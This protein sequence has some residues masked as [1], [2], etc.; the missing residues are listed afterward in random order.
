MTEHRRKFNSTAGIF[1]LAIVFA[2]VFRFL[3]KGTFYPTLFSYFRSFIYIGLFAAW[4]LSIRHRIVQKQARKYLTGA[5]VLLIFWLMVRTAKYFIFWQPEVMRYLWYSF[6][7]PMLFVPMMAVL[8]SISLG[9]PDDYRL[10]TAA[11]ILWAV[12]AALFLLVMSNDLHQAVFEFPHSSEVWTDSQHSYSW[13]YYPVIAWQVVCAVTAL[14]VMVNKC[15]EN[16]GGQFPLPVAPLAVSIAYSVLYY[17]GVPWLRYLFGDIAV[18]QSLMY[19]LAFEA[20]IACGYIH[21]NSRYAELFA[22]SVGTSVQITDNE[23]N[24]RYAAINTEP[25]SIPDMK[26]ATKAPVRLNNG[27]MLHTMSIS[28]GYAVWTEDVSALLNLREE[29]ESLA[30]ELKE[31]NKLLRYEYKREAKHHAVEEQNRLYDLLRSATQKQIDHIS[32]LMKEYQ[33]V[34]ETSPEIS[35]GLLAEIAVLCSYIKRR[36]HLTLL[37]DREQKIPAG[38]LERAFSES[39]QMLK[40]LDIRGMLYIDE[41]LSEV[42]GITSACLFDF[43]EEVIE[44]ALHDLKS[45]HISFADTGSLRLSMNVH[46]K[47]DLSDFARRNNVLYEKDD[48]YQR[49]VFFPEGGDTE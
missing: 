21:S 23:F 20:C 25:I 42:P 31:R 24:V 38:E 30:E 17:S 1:I 27:H 47:A 26:K 33:I 22:S 34:C 16:G 46:C 36:K 11:W 19:I 12:S 10:P 44:Y 5:A 3:G 35:S 32:G 45:V 6:Y 18:F 41:A 14:V 13:G 48:E 4:G 29:S 2:Y 9:R 8:I 40:L 39:L 37:T 7:L 43:Y 15:R 49:L 28:G